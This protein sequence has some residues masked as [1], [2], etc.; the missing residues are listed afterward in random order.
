MIDIET[1]L[2]EFPL[3][4]LTTGEFLL[5]QGEKTDSIYFL[6]EGSVKVVQDGYEVA[7]RSDK[8]TVFGDMSVILDHEHSASVQCLEDSE[9]Y[10]IEHPRKFLKDHPQVIWH[11][12][13]ILA[14]RLFNLTQYLVDV[15]RQ[16]VGHDHLDMVDDVL[17]TLLNQQK[18]SV[19]KR[20]DSKRDTPDY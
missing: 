10:H 9:F 8:G 20:G 11:I 15:K 17:A 2:S 7:V 19:L 6:R 12:T 3:I 4:S 16:Y 5:T 13:Q 14:L 1:D 18:T